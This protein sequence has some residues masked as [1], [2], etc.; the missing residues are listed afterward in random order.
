MRLG[1]RTPRLMSATM[2]FAV[3]PSAPRGVVG[4]LARVV[5]VLALTTVPLPPTILVMMA[6][7]SSLCGSNVI[8]MWSSVCLG[9]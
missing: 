4:F 5:E 2:R 8:C 1:R 6:M 9:E 7:S 3:S